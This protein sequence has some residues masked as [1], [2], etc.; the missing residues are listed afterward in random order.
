MSTL[1]VTNLKGGSAGSAPN[2]PDGAVI[3]GVATVGVL[4]ATTFYGSGANLTGIDATALKDS[5]GTVKVQANSDGAVVTGVLTATTG[6]FTSNVSVGGTLTYEDVTNIDSVGVIT[7]RSGIV[8]TGV[9]TATSFS[10]SGANLT[11]IDALPSVRGTASGAITAGRGVQLKTDGTYEQ[12][13]G[14]AQTI[15]TE[16]S[17]APGGATYAY[18]KMAF[19][20]DSGK[21][22]VLY[23]NGNNNT[24]MYSTVGTISGTSISWGTPDSVENVNTNGMQDICY[25]PWRNAFISACRNAGSGVRL[26]RGIISGTNM[27]WDNPTNTSVWGATTAEYHSLAANPDDELIGLI[28]KAQG[29]EATITEWHLSTTGAISGIGDRQVGN[30]A[31]YWCDMVYDT[32]SNA[33]IAAWTAGYASNAGTIVRCV[34]SG[35]SGSP[36]P[37]SSQQYFYSSGNATQ[38]NMVY[39][40][41]SDQ[42]II[43]FQAGG[44]MKSLTAKWSTSA[45]AFTFG[46][47][48]DV[49]DGIGSFKDG[50]LRVTY[51][52]NLKKLVY[53]M[54]N[55]T[56]VYVRSAAVSGTSILLDAQTQVSGQGRTD[57]ADVVFDS[58]T[59][60]V[61]MAY[62]DYAD[63]QN[64]KGRTMVPGYT[65]ANSATFVGLS[66]DTVANGQT[67]KVNTVSSISTQSGLTTASK[68]Y[69]Q[70]VDGSLAT[71]ADSSTGNI[72]AG[73]A[74]NS[75][76]LLI[77]S[78]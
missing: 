10:G 37:E 74:L 13:T 43:F 77:K 28:Y 38:I 39:D 40:P 7:A 34:S 17:G 15:N 14:G 26:E 67:V 58:T 68:Y 4:S 62:E 24:W 19:G 23:L 48:V 55:N 11:G 70:G 25:V 33:Y 59:N 66:N 49:S 57:F 73:M 22:A 69:V 44:V 36:G 20:S 3:T 35:G 52:T 31:S 76:Q 50:A 42:T 21:V 65:N 56:N 12:I 71:T 46:T 32:G 2:L 41:D 61:I 9:I 16:S 63:S 27:T 53:I 18:L 29:G 47:I 78:V 6:S 72:F 75:T 8:A 64:L 45:G 51:D 1:R 60:Q 54:G 5:G 30:N